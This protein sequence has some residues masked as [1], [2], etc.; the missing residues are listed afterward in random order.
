MK[1]KIMSRPQSGLFY[2]EDPYVFISIQD[3]G[4]VREPP[5]HITKRDAGNCMAVLALYF[6]DVD[7]IHD[8]PEANY[9]VNG[10]PANEGLFCDEQA[11][12][13]LD[14]YLEWKDMV[15]FFALHCNAGISRSS[16]TAAALQVVADGPRSDN[17]I[18]DDGRWHPNRWVYRTILKVAQQRGLLQ[19]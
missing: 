11:D 4:C 19:W 17:W 18:F 2:H 5:I 15:A 7:A 1:F 10:R 6:W 13:I 14:F 8:K 3:A 16:A 9:F 12:K